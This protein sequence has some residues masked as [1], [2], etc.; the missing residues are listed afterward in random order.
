MVLL[1]QSSSRAE[2]SNITF[3]EEMRM[4]KNFNL[5]MNLVFSLMVLLISPIS[6]ASDGYE[7]G[8]PFIS[9]LQESDLYLSQIQPI[10]DRRCT[11]CHSCFEA[12]CQMKLTSSDM[13]LRGATAHL[14]NGGLMSAVP[15]TDLMLTREQ[16]RAGGFFSV[17]EGGPNSILVKLLLAG[18]NKSDLP[19]EQFVD[20]ED[21]QCVATPKKL[22]SLDS[23][24]LKSLGM[25]YYMAALDSNE[26]RT[27]LDW[28]SNGAQTP[29]EKTL[30]RL[31]QPRSPQVIQDWENFF[32]GIQL[33][34]ETRWKSQWT[35]RY[36]YEHLFTAHFYFDQSP[37]E[38]YEI[39]RSK[40]A[41]PH[42]IEEIATERVFDMPRELENN[43]YYRLRKVQSTIIHKQHFVYH[44]QNHSMDELKKLFWYTKWNATSISHPFSFKDRN[45]FVAFVPIPAHAR[46]RWMLKNAKML[47]D[48]DMRSENCHGNGA[49]GPLRD[50]FLFVFVKPESDV[51][52][53]YPDFFKH[54]NPY[55]EMANTGSGNVTMNFRFKKNQEAYSQVKHNHQRGLLPNGF[56]FEDVWDGEAGQQ[57][58]FFTIMRHET[59]VTVHE[60]PWGPRPRVTLLFDYVS[61]ER[62]YYNCVG[63]TT[64]FDKI[65]DKLGTVL[66]LRDVGR[67][68]EEQLLSLI[69]NE[70]RDKVRAEWVQGEGAKKEN[71]YDVSK[72][73][74]PFNR[75]LLK[76]ADYKIDAQNPYGSMMDYL[77]L[78]SGRFSRKV[79]GTNYYPTAIET[80]ELSLLRETGNQMGREVVR[81]EGNRATHFPNISY[82]IVRNADGSVSYYTIIVNRF[83]EYVNHLPI[84]LPKGPNPGRV[85]KKDTMNVFPDIVANYPGKIYRISEGQIEKFV[86]DMKDVKNPADY[87]E[88]DQQYGLQKL[89]S[90]FWKTIDQIQTHFIRSDIIHNGSLDLNDYGTHDLVGSP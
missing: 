14:T 69:P 7:R 59:T 58:P 8:G 34:S 66:Y 86:Q 32:N 1:S 26:I 85:P 55:L 33:D 80:A 3:S 27:L 54:A 17:T 11:V 24:T 36:L 83:Y 79:I 84:P 22:D 45:P 72:F 76:I 56:T 78:K 40:T 44:I 77:L 19:K 57:M 48:M 82:L 49:A 51:S 52:V 13:L 15:R 37:G 75:E 42:K 29:S 47:L 68:A 71:M 4:K 35:S 53:R 38:F 25:P 63:L 41:A 65:T 89:S 67:E 87:K 10:L 9:H 90:D 21:R 2:S 81:G 50:N 16:Q 39:V 5:Y 74:L 31:A 43:F 70:L 64:L 20:L 6:L 23:K 73:S 60:G 88:F 61:F 46:Y 62:L 28:A 18:N 12:P 30:D